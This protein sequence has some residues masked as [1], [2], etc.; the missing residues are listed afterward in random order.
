MDM[1]SPYGSPMIAARQPQKGP[2]ARR[3]CADYNNKIKCAV[4]VRYPAENRGK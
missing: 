3:I 1:E 2:D 4:E